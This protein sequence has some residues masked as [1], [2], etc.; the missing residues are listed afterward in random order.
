MIL[1]TLHKAGVV[2][3]VRGRVVRVVDL[4]SL[5]LHRCGFESRQELDSFMRGNYP[6]RLRNV[7]GYTQVPACA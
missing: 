5:D 6:A 3:G 4:E 7:G 2:G 1:N